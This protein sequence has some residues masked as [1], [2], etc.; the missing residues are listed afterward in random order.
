MSYRR[1]NPNRVIGTRIAEAIQDNGSTYT[2][3]AEAADMRPDELERALLGE[4]P[5]TFEQLVRVGGF[6]HVRAS[7]LVK[8]VTT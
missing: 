5:L 2:V 4:K 1:R 7:A 6:L 3:V 8:G